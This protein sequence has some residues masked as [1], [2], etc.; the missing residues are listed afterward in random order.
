LAKI[1]QNQD[2]QPEYKNLSQQLSVLDDEAYESLSETK[3]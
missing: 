3:P 1:A 2:N